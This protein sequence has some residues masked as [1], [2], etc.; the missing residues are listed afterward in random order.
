MW[1]HRITLW[2]LIMRSV[3]S[4]SLPTTVLLIIPNILFS[5]SLP[6][7]QW[8]A[9]EKIVSQFHINLYSQCWRIM[10]KSMTI[11][12]TRSSSK[13]NL[14]PSYKDMSQW[15]NNYC[16]K[17]WASFIL[18]QEGVINVQARKSLRNNEELFLPRH[19]ALEQGVQLHSPRK[20]S[21]GHCTHC[22]VA[23]HPLASDA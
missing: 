1:T 22:K 14:P 7:W 6:Q 10:R 23:V 20:N 13:Q 3:I 9:E 2:S 4:F 8:M 17:R 19:Q 12:V 15:Q 5:V 11:T 16:R 18:W 21:G